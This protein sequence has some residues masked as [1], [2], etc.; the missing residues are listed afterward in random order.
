MLPW[1]NTPNSNEDKKKQVV[2]SHAA[3]RENL[4]YVNYL[5]F[6]VLKSYP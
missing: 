5:E 1:L 4:K 6:M 2:K 3:K